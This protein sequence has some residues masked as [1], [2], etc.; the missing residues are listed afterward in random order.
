VA[1]TPATSPQTSPSGFAGEQTPRTLAFT[2]YDPLPVALAGLGLIAGAALLLMRRR[3]PHR[4]P[5]R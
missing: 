3:R 2:G 4:G 5:R 1:T